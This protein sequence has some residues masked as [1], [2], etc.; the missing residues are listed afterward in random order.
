[1]KAMICL[2][3]AGLFI[4]PAWG[5]AETKDIP[6]AMTTA[7]QATTRDAAIDA[8]DTDGIPPAHERMTEQDA[9]EELSAPQTGEHGIGTAPTELPNGASD[10]AAAYG[11]RTAIAPVTLAGGDWIFIDGDE[12]RGWFFDRAMMTRNEDGS[13]SYWQL[14]LYNDFGRAQF[15]R[16]MNDEAYETLCYTLQRRVLSLRENTIRTYEIIAYDGANAIIADS[17]RDG[18]PTEIH[19]NTM[20]EKERDAV[21]K[22]AKKLKIRK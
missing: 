2:L 17:S 6:A 9:A 4:L 5:S 21:K 16:A 7:E 14:I 20:A 13:I 18:H 11:E 8:Q 22:T 1:M 3:T 15:V 12:R 10:D 19:P